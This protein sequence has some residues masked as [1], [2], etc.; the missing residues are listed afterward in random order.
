MKVWCPGNVFPQLID[1]PFNPKSVL[2]VFQTNLISDMSY[3]CTYGQIFSSPK[4]L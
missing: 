2:E 1:F 4:I 3:L